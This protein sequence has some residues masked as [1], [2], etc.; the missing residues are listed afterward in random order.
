M[1]VSNIV[2]QKVRNDITA[3]KISDFFTVI[4]VSLEILKMPVS[5]YF[6]TALELKFPPERNDAYHHSTFSEALSATPHFSWFEERKTKQT[7]NAGQCPT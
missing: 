6:C 5:G 3:P 7:R 4:G 2:V 1:A